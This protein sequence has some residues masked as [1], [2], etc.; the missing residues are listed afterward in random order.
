MRIQCLFFFLGFL[1]LLNGAVFAADCPPQITTSTNMTD[2]YAGAPNSAT[3]ATGTACVKIGAS[4][5]IF[6][7]NGFNI[8]NNGTTGNT[9]GILLNGS[10]TNVTVKN[11][12]GISGYNY[13]VYLYQSS[14]NTITNNTANCSAVSPGSELYRCMLNTTSVPPGKYTLA[15]LAYDFAS[16][17]PGNNATATSN[18]TLTANQEDAYE[19]DGSIGQANWIATDGA[20]QRHNFH[21]ATD[22]DFVKFNATAGYTYII[23]TVTRN[24]SGTIDT[25]MALYNA[26]GTTL[27]YSDDIVATTNVS[28]RIMFRAAQN[29][30]YYAA[31]NEYYG[32]VGGVYDLFVQQQ[33]ILVASVVNVTSSTLQPNNSLNIT[34]TVTCTGGPCGNVT[35]NLDPL[36]GV[37]QNTAGGN[38]SVQAKLSLLDMADKY[39]SVPVIVK[40]KDVKQ[41]VVSEPGQ[42]RGKTIQLMVESQN[43]VLSGL[44]TAE[45]QPGYRYTIINGFSGNA[46]LAG[47]EK[48]LNDSRVESVTYDRV[49]HVQLDVSVPLINATEVWNITVNGSSM[50]GTGQTVCILDTGINY[51]HPDFGSCSITNNIND[52]SCPK[53][54]GG[55]DFVNTDS[56]PR[57]DQGHG[58]HVAGIVA[59]MDATYRGVAPGA[60]IVMV[61]VCNAAGSCSNSNML[62]GM[63]WCVN[64]ASLFNISAIS[65]SIGGGA[66]VDGWDCDLDD[67]AMT[68]AINSA[69]ANNLTVMVASGNGINNDGQG[70]GYSNPGGL[71]WPACIKSAVSVGAT[72]DSDAIATFTDRNNQLD[73][74]APGVGILATNYVGTHTSKD[75]T[76]M[77]TP[78]VSG[79]VALLNQYYLAKYN[80]RPTPHELELMMER[81]GK[82]INDSTGRNPLTYARINALASALDKGIISTNS[83]ARPFYTTS[84]NPAADSCLTDMQNGTSCNSTWRVV[85]TGDSG[86]YTFFTI[87]E[88]T[89]DTFYTDN[90]TITILGNLTNCSVISE[91]GSYQLGVNVSGAPNNAT[92]VSGSACIKIAASN[93]TFDCAGFSITNNGTAGTTYGILLNG[94][95]T[96]VTVK[97]C[98]NVSGYAYGI[99]I[100]QSN[101]NNFTN[102]TATNNSV[103]G[104]YSGLSS[105]QVF[106]SNTASFSAYGFCLNTS[107][108]NNVL[109]NN[110][111]Y[112]N[113][114]GFYLGVGNSSSSNYNLLDSNR[115]YNN[116]FSGFNLS[117]INYTSLINNSAYD[118]GHRGFSLD[119]CF[120]NNIT[121]NTARN[122]GD[123]G[124]YTYIFYYNNLTNN[125]AY[126]NTLDGF[127]LEP[128]ANDNRFS[129]NSVYNNGGN[130]FNL[131]G[132]NNNSFILNLVYG[133]GL[134]SFM[135]GWGSNNTFTNNSVYN[136]AES[137]TYMN[138]SVTSTSVH[139]YNNSKDILV[140]SSTG[141]PMYVKLSTVVFDNPSG[142]YSQFTTLSL[143]DS[144]EPGSAYEI[145]W[146]ANTS[147]LPTGYSSFSR[148]F[149]KIANDTTNGSIDTVVWSWTDAEAST[150]GYDESRFSLW[151]YNASGWMRLNAS[152]DTSGNT[153]SLSAL[154]V[155][156]VIGILQLN[157]T[158]A[159][160]VTLNAP[161]DGNISTSSSVTL[162]FTA[163][164][165]VDITLPCGIYINSILNATVN[166]TNGTQYNHTQ[167]YA[168]ANYTWYVNCSDGSGNYGVS[169]NRTFIVDALSPAITI[170]SPANNTLYNT[171]TILVN[172]SVV[173]VHLASTWFFNG[174]ANE[175]YTTPVNRT[176]ADGNYN[177]SVW[178]NDTAGHL[179][180]A[181]AN[182]SVDTIYPTI[183]FV[184]P[185]F[186]SSSSFQVDYI[187]VNVS[188]ND[189]RLANI[190]IMLYNSS[191]A[192]INSSIN[193]STT[194]PASY[195]YANFTGLGDGTYYFN[196]TAYDRSGHVNSTATW[197]VTLDTVAP[198]ITIVSP[199]NNTLYNTTTI[200]VNISVVE[201]H[202]ASTWFFNGTANETYT[203]PVNRTY[204]D[205]NYNL[206]VWSN[207]TAGHL[208]TAFVNF[209]V[210]TVVPIVTLSTPANTSIFNVS[211]MTFNFT[212]TDNLAATMNCSLYIDGA[213]NRSNASTA[214][215]T[216]TNITLANIPDGNHTWSVRCADTANGIGVSE[217]RVFLTDTTAPVVALNAPA[218]LSFFNQSSVLLNFTPG[219]NLF[220][221]LN[222]SLYIDGALNSTNAS[223]TNGTLTTFPASLAEGN[224]SWYARCI[225]GANN[226][227]TSETRN[228][229]VDLTPPA[230]EFIPYTDVSG[231]IVS[232]SWFA[233]HI[234]AT[235]LNLDNMTYYVFNSTGPLFNLTNYAA[236]LIDATFNWTVPDG[237]YYF[238]ATAYDKARNVNTTET[239]NITLD[240]LGPAITLNSPANN[241]ASNASTV[242]FNFTATDAVF[243][244][245]NCSLYLDGAY[246]QSN[247]ATANNTATWFTV[248]NIATGNHNWSVR[249]TDGANNTNTSQTRLFRT[250]PIAP[251][252]TLNSP[253]NASIFNAST[254]VFSF[255]ALD[256]LDTTLNC[257]LVM[258]GS[259]AQTNSSTQNGTAT[260][261]TLPGL[262]NTNHQWSVQCTDSANNTNASETR[263]FFVDTIVPAVTLNSPA[264]ASAFNATT[265]VFNFTATDNAVPT[266]N[267]SLYLDGTLNATN[268][269]APNGTATAFTVSG[270]ANGS[271]LWGVRCTDIANNTG[272]SQTRTFIV[273]TVAPVVTLNSPANNT[274]FNASPTVSFTFTAVDTYSSSMAC[275]L[276]IGGM[277]T[278][279]PAAANDTPT[280]VSSQVPNGNLTWF[281]SCTDSAGNTGT[282]GAL[283]ISMNYTYVPSESS[284]KAT[285]RLSAA[286]SSSCGGNVVTVTSGRA[287]SGARVVIDG[288]TSYYTD[289]NGQINFTG[290]GRMVRIHA[291]AEG[292]MPV[293]TDVELV[294]CA[295]CACT[296]DSCYVTP[297][298]CAD[299]STCPGDSSCV[300]GSCGVVSCLCGTVQDHQ[301]MAYQCCS[302]S[303]CTDG[304][305][306]TNHSCVLPMN[307]SLDAQCGDIQ[308]C[309]NGV[310]SNVVGMCGYAVSHSWTKYACGPEAGCPACGQGQSCEDAK[311][312]P[313]EIRVPPNVS[314]GQNVPIQFTIG[315][316]PCKACQVQITDPGGRSFGV[317][318]DANGNYSLPT[319]MA[320]AYKVTLVRNGL[321]VKSLTFN[322][323]AR[324]SGETS[325]PPSAQ[326]TGLPVLP[327]AAAVVILLGAGGAYLLGRKPRQPKG[328]PR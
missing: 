164:D 65:I 197:N 23:Q 20:M 266:L 203:T 3:P 302:D 181:F 34:T 260:L 178:S 254:V 244:T 153:L 294:D 118:N 119:F 54:V 251:N 259:V 32:N 291:S 51:T 39:G 161:A 93:V 253:G 31:V 270:F 56:D 15:V 160:N 198:A 301:C 92:P 192:M 171:S 219:D 78:H 325:V 1:L 57:D 18:I 52:G 273:D 14:N 288:L 267:C 42:K 46:T 214:N 73:V 137:G 66:Y 195:L 103:A 248:T 205:G 102:N 109:S 311:C 180:T 296:G 97:N 125:S 175:T 81:D 304:K 138:T 157:D 299:D 324:P 110:I 29:G 47:L 193:A 212:A 55:Y 71:A 314:V 155:S 280:T 263:S 236:N 274:L 328:I 326:G 82:A 230:L 59:S 218:N 202:L 11:C 306:C 159:P 94:S 143:N 120:Y 106:I 25:E 90:R 275:A 295:L 112:N 211:N 113:T 68:S 40:L 100:Y 60:K 187:P 17:P 149:I 321:S 13:S 207:D 144:V 105:G 151:T 196:A 184:A 22:I 318:T 264:N 310:C 312:K 116:T 69:V 232:R 300:D 98:G 283:N 282:S 238:N 2:N 309:D 169:A 166:A 222:C 158:L 217:T 189:T 277:Q 327:I 234:T 162:S 108:D 242:V 308:R 75:G 227:G 183:D 95:L 168:D 99:Y 165:E 201:V 246:N 7:C 261:F 123:Y 70:L 268:A 35:A 62:A 104:F 256:N 126:L 127:R 67:A 117:R 44:S 83:S 237:T 209:S 249:C 64:N 276:F 247:N 307:C 96:N 21:N 225:D 80:R 50:N 317:T 122:N 240:T 85:A 285:P 239:R 156:S 278:Q 292:Y 41:S 199:A 316:A 27:A 229:T 12:P 206:T 37:A 136:S 220:P 72:D 224:H 145:N 293:D 16:P 258:D 186:N 243:T 245:L 315:N 194:S 128:T 284:N 142:N 257:S 188:A 287:I 252:V 141:S 132:A 33:G 121:N 297:Q 286:V 279:S 319:A 213:F 208:S 179:S 223:A 5:V 269:T 303:E 173:E 320:G 74:L 265:V 163:T 152:P 49:L 45:F 77:A 305:A 191:G 210:D 298:P 290:C 10:A 111:A 131:R 53:V 167:A 36:P 174:T 150:G 190:T 231:I 115:A 215:N 154:T 43:A 216:L 281:V 8:T 233:F 101:N 176:Y 124:F 130:G 134:S 228:L 200:L 129:N 61:K 139:Y 76:S 79:L 289:G 58:S 30:T 107:T 185:T 24:D 4:N 170:V 87:Y 322:A 28:S 26:S 147:A 63:Q 9:T 250:D 84:S 221:Q 255:T 146:S 182:F 262:G 226:T 323:L 91:S 133:N 19:P 38:G 204:A 272:V 241:S 177:L 88:T 6:D 271:Y 86:N 89:Y 313:V 48:L 235:D 172:I 148:K 135:I 114:D 140:N